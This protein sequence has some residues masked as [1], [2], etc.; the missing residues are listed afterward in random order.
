MKYNKSKMFLTSA[1]ILFAALLISGYRIC[2]RKGVDIGDDYFYK[3]SNEVYKADNHNYL[4]LKNQKGIENAVIVLDGEKQTAQLF[5]DGR[6]VEI[7][8]SDGTIVN[9]TWGNDG[10]FDEEGVPIIYSEHYA[11]NYVDI[12]TDGKPKEVRKVVL[13]E[14]L[15]RISQAAVGT[16]GSA[17]FMLL[18]TVLYVLG[19]LI[20]KNPE[21][22]FFFLNKWRYRE[23]ELSEAGKAVERIG[24]IVVMIVGAVF[25]SGIFLVI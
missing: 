14:A 15:S 1:L 5:W 25:L 2:L 8:Y 20:I 6:N 3:V 9:G 17:G 10:L 13:S 21:A 7:T 11:D 4:E 23:A 19:I 24:G 18:G 12:G 22:S 16:R